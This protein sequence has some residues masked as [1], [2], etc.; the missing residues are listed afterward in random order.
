MSN[1]KNHIDDDSI[2]N[3]EPFLDSEFSQ[4]Q[5]PSTTKDSTESVLINQLDGKQCDK[6]A[7]GESDLKKRAGIVLANVKKVGAESYITEDDVVTGNNKLNTLFTAAI[8]NACPGLDPPTEQEAYEAA[9]LLEDDAKG[10]REERAFRM[11]I[12]SLGLDGVRINNLYEECRSGLLLLTLIDKIN[13][14]TVNWKMVDKNAKNPF[15]ATVNCNEVINASKKSGY[16]IVGIGGADIRDGNK[17]YILAIVWQLMREHTL[18]VIG[19]K[20]EEEL[21]TW[22]NSMVSEEYKISSLKDKKLGNSLF[23]IEIMAGIESRAINWELVEPADLEMNAKYAVS[24][25]RK[26]GACVLLVWED[27]TEIKSRLLLTF[28]AS[29]YDVAQNY[30]KK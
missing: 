5:E 23:F 16:S 18:Q 21:L 6:S 24:V 30:V 27:I 12:N 10:G 1:G 11:W 20:S 2:S 15:K 4:L 17:K 22:G 9:K 8:F 28:I 19:G 3:F 29:L 7:L 13:P 26:L 14:G 25:A